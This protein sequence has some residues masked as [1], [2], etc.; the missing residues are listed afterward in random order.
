MKIAMMLRHCKTIS[1]TRDLL[2]RK[3]FTE[4]AD[5]EREISLRHIIGQTFRR[6]AP[7][8]DPVV[9]VAGAVASRLT[10]PA[11]PPCERRAGPGNE[12]DDLHD[13]AESVST[14]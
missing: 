7:E 9:Q 6:A 5:P 11:C 8:D 14:G 4:L 1:F 13:A 3:L 10:F 12:A 2:G